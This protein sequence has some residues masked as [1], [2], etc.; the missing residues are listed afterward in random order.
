MR[1]HSK[2]TS[3]HVWWKLLMP[4]KSANNVSFSIYISLSPEPRQDKP[5][6]ANSI[7]VGAFRFPNNQQTASSRPTDNGIL[8]WTVI[9]KLLC[10]AVR[11]VVYIILFNPSNQPSSPPSPLLTG[12]LMG[13]YGVQTFLYRRVLLGSYNKI[14]MKNRRQF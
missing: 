9:S 3:S 14:A 8:L 2:S 11:C 5:R 7:Q 10:Y 6:S 12:G 13:R 4:G 1:F